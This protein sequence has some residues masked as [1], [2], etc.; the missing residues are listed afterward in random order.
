MHEHCIRLESIQK[1]SIH[2]INGV[3][4]DYTTFCINNNLPSLYERC[5]ELSKRF[6]TTMHYLRAVVCTTCCL[7]VKILIL[8]PSCIIPVSTVYLLYGLNVLSIHLLITL[9]N[10]ISNLTLCMCF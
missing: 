10:I 5:C 2:I 3:T 1:R 9:L 4:E 7:I 8:L 6:S